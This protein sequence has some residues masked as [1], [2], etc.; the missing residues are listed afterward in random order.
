M[1]VGQASTIPS[2]RSKPWRNPLRSVGLTGSGVHDV[3]FTPKRGE[4]LGVSGLMG[5]GRTE[6]MKVIYG[7]LP[8][9]R[10]VINLENKTINPVS[11]KDCRYHINISHPGWRLSLGSV[12]KTCLFVHWIYWPKVVKSNT[13]M[14]WSRWM[15]SSSY[16]T[17][18]PLLASKS[19][20]TFLVVTNRKSLSLRA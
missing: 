2:H 18:R 3:S 20:A 13:K 12:K 10:G 5:A 8:S 17:S 11:P 9:E 14:K 16:S 15:T 4:I 1:M 6:L 7:A 19:L